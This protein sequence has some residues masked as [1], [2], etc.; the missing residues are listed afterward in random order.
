MIGSSTQLNAVNLRRS[1]TIVSILILGS[2]LFGCYLFETDLVKV[3]VTFAGSSQHPRIYHVTVTSGGDKALGRTVESSETVSTNL[4]PDDAD[5]RH[6]VLTY[7][8][9]DSETEFPSAWDGPAIPSGKG[10][11]IHVTID[12][13]TKTDAVKL[14]VV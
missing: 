9:S 4:F 10:Y 7:K 8:W 12:A 14:V 5:D 3:D 1:L 13:R 11:R 6:L 2:C